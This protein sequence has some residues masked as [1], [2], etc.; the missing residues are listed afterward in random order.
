MLPLST[1]LK[2]VAPSLVEEAIQIAPILAAKQ[3]SQT[4]LD[5]DRLHRDFYKLSEVIRFAISGSLGTVIFFLLERL[6]Y[7]GLTRNAEKLPQACRTYIDGMSYMAAYIIQIVPQHLF[8][9]LLVYGMETI[10]TRAKYVKTLIGCYSTYLLAMIGS[11]FLNT[12]LI[13]N[14]V[15]RN[16]AFV[17]TLGIFSCVNYLLLHHINQTVTRKGTKNK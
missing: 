4:S 9:A 7:G 13:K 8:N 6:F 16:V 11:T 5:F 3:M 1:S 12:A 17:L 15:D 14:G 2:S 10:S